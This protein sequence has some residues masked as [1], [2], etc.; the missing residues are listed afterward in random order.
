MDSE[1]PPTE[2]APTVD[3][4]RRYP[5]AFKEQVLAECN[6]PGASVAGVAIRHGLN[7]N[8]VHKWRKAHKASQENRFLRLPAPAAPTAETLLRLE[9]PTP[10]GTLIVHWPMSELQQ[11]IAWLRALTR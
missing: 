9:V 1:A 10:K 7:A 8:L 2:L 6:E 5:P 3:R 11:S 4:R